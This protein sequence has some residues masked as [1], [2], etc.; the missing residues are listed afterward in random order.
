MNQIKIRWLVNQKL[1]KLY[2][3]FK[4]SFTFEDKKKVSLRPDLH[5][6]NAPLYIHHNHN[7]LKLEEKC[8]LKCSKYVCVVAW[9]TSVRF[10]LLKNASLGLIN[11]VEFSLWVLLGGN[12]RNFFPSCSS[13]CMMIAGGSTYIEADHKKKLDCVLV[14]CLV[15]Y[16]LR[17]KKYYS[18]V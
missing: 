15:W 2:H 4:H 6:I 5:K 13:L 9:F 10:F 1:N 18:R 17:L 7:E 11:N 12:C 14:T 8:N 3:E 16:L